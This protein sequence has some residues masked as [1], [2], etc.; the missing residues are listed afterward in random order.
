MPTESQ[1]LPVGERI[2]SIPH[3]TGRGVIMA[4]ID[5]GFSMHPD[6]EDRVLVLVDA[7]TN[8]V[9]EQ[10]DIT[11]VSDMN[12]HGQM[13]SVI[14]AGNGAISAGKYRGVASDAKLILVKVSTPDMQ[15]KEADILR[16][17]RWI[18]DTC[19]RFKTQIVNVSV[20]GDFVNSNRNYRLHRI[21]EKLALAGITVVTASGN[22]GKNRIVP[23]ASSPHALTIG[24]YDNH[25]VLDQEIWSLYH[26]NYG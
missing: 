21:I 25:N 2:G 4:F 17:L 22:H 19:R 12:W 20:G 5:S 11:S 16:G 14:A 9:I 10:L 8:R 3:Y 15:I 7:S 23:P 24:G 1:I 26:H 13:T 6:I 18:Y